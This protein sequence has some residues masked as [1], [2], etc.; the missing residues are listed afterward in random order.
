MGETKKTIQGLFNLKRMLSP[1]TIFLN[2]ADSLFRQR[3]FGDK[4]WERNRINQLLQEMDGLKTAKTPPFVLLATNFPSDLDHAV[5]RR[6]PSRIYISL[7]FK[8]DRIRIFQM[9]LKNK[10]LNIDI[11]IN[12]LGKRS[13]RYTGSDIKTLCI[14]AAL[15][16]DI[17]V[18]NDEESRQL[19]K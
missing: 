8:D 12:S 1:C 10:I 18:N 19:L 4:S 2:E 16:R 6:V 11:N 15:I 5:L 13:W 9:C 7:P 17:F 14:Q 3:T